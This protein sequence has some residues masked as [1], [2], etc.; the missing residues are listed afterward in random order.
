MFLSSIHSAQLKS[1]FNQISTVSRQQS[2]SSTSSSSSAE[3]TNSSLPSSIVEIIVKSNENLFKSAE[4]LLNSKECLLSSDEESLFKS[5]EESLLKSDD[6][7][8]IKST[9]HSLLSTHENLFKCLSNTDESLDL[10]NLNL[11]SSSSS[12]DSSSYENIYSLYPISQRPNSTSSINKSKTSQALSYENDERVARRRN[13]SLNEK[14]CGGASGYSNHYLVKETY[15]KER[16]CLSCRVNLI[17]LNLKDRKSLTISIKW[18]LSRQRQNDQL[19]SIRINPASN[20]QP[21]NVHIKY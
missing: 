19:F 9:N 4:N 11:V 18:P 15:L 13:K 1:T 12:L 20:Q 2:I 7:L 16:D 8:Q 6:I 14:N 17:E 3:S 10:N 5:A 21:L